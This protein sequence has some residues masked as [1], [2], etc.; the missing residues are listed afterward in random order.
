MSM[1]KRD[2]REL[3]ELFDLLRA[4]TTAKVDRPGTSHQVAALSEIERRARAL[5]HAD[6]VLA[7]ADGFG[8]R[9]PGNGSPGS[10]KGGRPMMPIR[11]EEAP[12]GTPPDLVP[13]SSTEVAALALSP[14]DPV[15]RR[16]VR[17]REAL[18]VV[19]GALRLARRELDEWEQDRSTRVASDPPFCWLAQVRYGMVWDELW[20]VEHRTDFAGVLPERLDEPRPVCQFVYLFTRR[21]KR[22]PTRDEMEQRLQRTVVR[23]AEVNGAVRAS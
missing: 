9:T 6:Q 7:A 21:M 1:S 10:G 4:F 19:V 20:T 3:D 8:A 22:L 12:V 11:D 18:D 13:T 16:A 23:T 5:F 14:P 17:V 2:E 15:H